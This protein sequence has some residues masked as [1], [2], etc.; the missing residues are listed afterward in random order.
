[1]RASF[2]LTHKCAADFDWLRFILRSMEDDFAHG[3][4]A[5]HE[6]CSHVQH[7]R[8]LGIAR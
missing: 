8:V 4:H 7:K 6:Q 3:E 2:M 5:K 1:M